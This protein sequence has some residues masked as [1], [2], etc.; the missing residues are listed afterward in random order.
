MSDDVQ[1]VTV[2]GSLASGPVK[3]ALVTCVKKKIN[4][5]CIELSDH[6]GNYLTAPSNLPGVKRED[7]SHMGDNSY[8]RTSNGR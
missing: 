8:L 6:S 4:N 5:F 2:L 7:E 3:E 1:V